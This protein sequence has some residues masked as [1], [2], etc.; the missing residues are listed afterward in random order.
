VAVVLII[1]YFANL[2]YTLYTHRDVFAFEEH[3]HQGEPWPLWQSIA[4]L[5]GATVLTALMS[6]LVSGA[7]E[8]SADTLGVTTFFLGIIVLALIGNAAE[9]LSAVYFA[10]QGR[11]GLALSLTVGSTIQVALLVAPVLVLVSWVM[12]K[13]MNLVFDNPLELIAIAAAAFIVRDIASDGETTWFEGVLLIGVY[14]VLGLA[15]FLVD[16]S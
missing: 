10:R 15:F 4:V 14:F 8:A 12:G 16:A 9:Y 2:A 11:M 3:P 13:P 5:L 1:V 7:L 6:E